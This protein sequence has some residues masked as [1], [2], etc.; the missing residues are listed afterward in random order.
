VVEHEPLDPD[1]PLWDMP[2][3]LI[4]PHTAAMNEQEDRLIADL[5]A[6]NATRFL[7]GR[8][9]INRVNTVEFY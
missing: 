8:E 5:F 6:E 9:L 4:S 2:N 7:D 3:V 1:S